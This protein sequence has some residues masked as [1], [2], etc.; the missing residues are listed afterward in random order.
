MSMNVKETIQFLRIVQCT[1]LVPCLLGHTGIGKTQIVEQLARELNLDLIV[2]HVATLEPSDFVGLY[3]IIENHTMNCSPGWLPYKEVPAELKDKV[4]LIPHNQGYINPN[5]GILFLDEVNRGHED[6]R[7]ALYQLLNTKRIHTY[8][9]PDNYHIVAAANP[10]ESYEVYEFDNA[11][12]NRFAWI[13]F[14]PEADETLGYLNKTYGRNLITTWLSKDLGGSKQAVNSIIDYGNDS[15]KVDGLLYTP[16]SVENH[17]K[18][19][20]HLKVC[21]KDFQIKALQ[22]IMPEELVSQFITY[23]EE[24]QQINW[25]DIVLGQN[26]DKVKQVITEDRVDVLAFVTGDL[27][28]FFGKYEFGKTEIDLFKR[29]DEEEV[30]KRVAD[31]FYTMK[32]KELSMVFIDCLSTFGN[33]RSIDQQEFFKNKIK[34]DKLASGREAL[35]HN[36]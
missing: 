30:I 5:G 1:N 27:A 34:K 20:E 28:E 16:R 19:W 12:K 2:L 14:I 24:I 6:I 23:C 3:Q 7:Q 22:T 35:K 36:K 32:G 31:F 17:I 26:K 9:L 29:E 18:L 21:K 15:F 10:T 4:E 11:A 13:K 33:L 25:K 8:S